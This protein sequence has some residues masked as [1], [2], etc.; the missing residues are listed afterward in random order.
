AQAEQ[1]EMVY[2]MAQFNLDLLVRAYNG[3]TIIDIIRNSIAK[4]NAMHDPKNLELRS[5]MNFVA[6]I[7]RER[8]MFKVRMEEK[9]SR[10][11]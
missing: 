2:F 9:K 8:A 1:I 4:Y 6:K 11:N 5:L 7:I 3:D 10:Q